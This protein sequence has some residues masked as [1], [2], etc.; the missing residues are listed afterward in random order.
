[1]FKWII[2]KWYKHNPECL[3]GYKMK[4]VDSS[5]DYYNWICIWKKCGWEAFDNGNG[6]L[7]WLKKSAK[8][9]RFYLT[10]MGFY[11]YIIVDNEREY[12]RFENF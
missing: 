8:Q 4:S 2:N 10:R 12:E 9:C 3:C 7:H 5:F 6:K 11:P 1:M